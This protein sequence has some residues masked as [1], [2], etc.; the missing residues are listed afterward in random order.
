MRTFTRQI[1]GWGIH[2]HPVI[3]IREGAWGSC[4]P[5]TGMT[6][7]LSEPV[8]NMSGPR[9]Q[10]MDPSDPSTW[11]RPWAPQLTGLIGIPDLNADGAS[12]QGR[13]PTQLQRGSQARGRGRRLKMRP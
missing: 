3:H 5:G 1:N 6:A 11:I 8:A 13:T 4:R 9:Y 2:N 10:G 7:G 12:L